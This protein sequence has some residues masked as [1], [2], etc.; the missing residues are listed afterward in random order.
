MKKITRRIF[1]KFLALALP[2]SAVPLA[3]MGSKAPPP[4]ADFDLLGMFVGPGPDEPII[5]RTKHISEKE[6]RRLYGP[7]NHKFDAINYT[8]QRYD[9]PKRALNSVDDIGWLRGSQ[10]SP[11]E[12]AKIQGRQRLLNCK[13][14]KLLDI[15]NKKV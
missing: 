5:W 15:I 3:P 14:S 4:P 1:L 8:V 11:G 2:A 13:R 10:W 7:G 12:I 9:G 6:W